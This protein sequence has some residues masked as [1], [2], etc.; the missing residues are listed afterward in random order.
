MR[1]D[2]PSGQKYAARVP[3]PDIDCSLL[4]IASLL[5]SLLLNMRVGDITAENYCHIHFILSSKSFSA[6]NH[7]IS[8]SI[9]SGCTECYGRSM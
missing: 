8:E 5:L 9:I 4:R 7:P 1:S 3:S 6:P 2:G